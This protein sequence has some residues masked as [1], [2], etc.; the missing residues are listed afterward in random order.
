MSSFISKTKDEQCYKFL[1]LNEQLFQKSCD[2]L[3]TG[4]ESTS[5]KESKICTIGYIFEYNLN[6]GYAILKYD[7]SNL[8]LD[9]TRISKNFK[10]KKDPYYIYG[11]LKRRNNEIILS[12]NYFRFLN[13]GFDYENYKSIVKN[14]R[15]IQQ[16]CENLS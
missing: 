7:N 16:D 4:N 15:E 13:V 11:D 12:V 14:I 9:L 1:W 10:H 6:E 2:L 3:S 8:K 5:V